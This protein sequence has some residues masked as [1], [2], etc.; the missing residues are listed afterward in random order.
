VVKYYS[1][2]DETKQSVFNRDNMTI[3]DEG[4]DISVN[5]LVL[6]QHILA[7][8]IKSDQVKSA[9]LAADIIDFL[10]VLLT[11]SNVILSLYQTGV[12]KNE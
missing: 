3:I 6:L 9:K 4:M 5:I 10:L 8:V 11:H 12:S 7:T 1:F 2:W